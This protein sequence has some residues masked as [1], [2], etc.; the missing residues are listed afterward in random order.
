MKIKHFFLFFILFSLLIIPTT[1]FA[2]QTPCSTNADCSTGEF[3]TSLGYCG[4]ASCEYDSQCPNGYFCK[5][6]PTDFS[7]SCTL[8][9]PLGGTCD[10]DGQCLQGE[11]NSQTQKCE[12]VAGTGTVSCT[13]QTACPDN[14][15]CNLSL[16]PS[17][18]NPKESDGS[19]C[20]ENYECISNICSQDFCIA[21]P[22]SP[23]T[24]TGDPNT[25]TGDPNTNTGD[26]NTN[27]GAPTTQSLPNPLGETN[28]NIIL[29]RIV[30]YIIGIS[31]SVALVVFIIGGAMWMISAGR[32]DYVKKGRAAMIS[33]IIGL[34]IIF[35]SY[36]IIRFIIDAAQ[37]ID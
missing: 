19:P 31:G 10:G 5:L 1:I 17:I 28:I 9:I 16:S 12:L 6:N 2:Q 11:C 29:G 26:P 23:L 8:K 37:S 35:S 15:F 7:Q 25:N 24:N 33:A 22:N 21:D 13:S 30:K 14:Q 3:C 27:T 34:A 20:T 18:C 4:S 36:I 32:P